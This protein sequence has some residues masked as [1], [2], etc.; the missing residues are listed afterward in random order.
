M[1]DVIS[2][3]HVDDRKVI[4]AREDSGPYLHRLRYKTKAFPVAEPTRKMQG[5]ARAI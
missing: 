5:N 2:V 1:V 3:Q 4:T